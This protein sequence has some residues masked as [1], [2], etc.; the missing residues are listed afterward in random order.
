VIR[1]LIL[2]P[3]TAVDR[4]L[5]LPGRIEA[6]V[7]DAV[8]ALREI[9]EQTQQIGDVPVALLNEMTAVKEA[10]N[11]TNRQLSAM[12]EQMARVLKL[13]AP[14]QRAQ[15][16][17][18]RLRSRLGLGAPAESA[19]APGTAEPETE[20]ETETAGEITSPRR[21]RVRRPRTTG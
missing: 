10:M 9:R 4:L 5:D 3:G 17:G 20:T 8:I 12:N 21:S 18:E 11:E 16:R 7:R 1:D 15:E 6:E 2:R 14:I 13:S 19:A